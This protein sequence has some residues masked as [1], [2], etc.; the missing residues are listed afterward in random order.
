MDRCFK[1]YHFVEREIQCLSNSVN[2]L[3]RNNSGNSVR[4]VIQQGVVG[5]SVTDCEQRL[6]LFTQ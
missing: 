6:L 3:L 5:L 1:L 4:V 2:G